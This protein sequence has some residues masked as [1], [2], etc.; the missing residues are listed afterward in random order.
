MAQTYT[1]HVVNGVIVLDEGNP[2]LTEG[3]KVLIEPTQMQR[4]GKRGRKE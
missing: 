4:A 3:T 2:A 1:G